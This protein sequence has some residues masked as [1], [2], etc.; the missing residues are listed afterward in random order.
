MLIVH[1]IDEPLFRALFDGRLDITRFTEKRIELHMR[2]QAGEF[3]GDL[4]KEAADY[5]ERIERCRQFRATDS[6]I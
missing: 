5:I 2:H 1:P 3:I 6:A 4:Q